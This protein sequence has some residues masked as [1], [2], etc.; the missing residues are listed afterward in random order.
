MRKW[1]SHIIH[2]ED[3]SRELLIFDGYTKNSPA[4]K[5]KIHAAAIPK[6]NKNENYISLCLQKDIKIL[7]LSGKAIPLSYDCPIEDLRNAT[8][9]INTKTIINVHQLLIKKNGI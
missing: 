4:I 7:P 2:S 6:H 9:E 1:N 3:L 5:R 8:L